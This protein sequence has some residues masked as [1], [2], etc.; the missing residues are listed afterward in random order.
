MAV[1]TVVVVKAAAD[2]GLLL[3]AGQLGVGGVAAA[4]VG[5]GALQAKLNVKRAIA[6]KLGNNPFGNIVAPGVP[7]LPAANLSK[8]A[9]PIKPEFPRPEPKKGGYSRKN[10]KSSG[11]R[12]RKMLGGV[13]GKLLVKNTNIYQQLPHSAKISMLYITMLDLYKNLQNV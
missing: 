11:T 1:E 5:A 6:P 7:V 13:Y 2:A 9:D 10:K 8:P 3:G 12:K 4:V